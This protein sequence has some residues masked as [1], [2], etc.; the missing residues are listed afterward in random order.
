MHVP[1]KL[2]GGT[3][4]GHL[5]AFR[6]DPIG[7]LTQAAAHADL[8]RT[9]LG[10]FDLAIVSAPS[11]VQEVLVD[12]AEQFEKSYGLSLFARPLLGDGLL[13]AKNE[14]HRRQRKLLAPAFVHK[15]IA[16]YAQ[17]SSLHAEQGLTRL[18]ARGTV[19]RSRVAGSGSTGGTAAAPRE[20]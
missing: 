20:R 8:V 13:T 7:L 17:I 9:R 12:H 5:P 14:P 19:E 15:R 3:W 10:V 4:L 6:S 2:P 11:L 1:P 18:L 16:S